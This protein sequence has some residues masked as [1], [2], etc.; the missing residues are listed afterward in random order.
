MIEIIYINS[1]KWNESQKLYYW[2]FQ[3]MAFGNKNRGDKSS[4]WSLTEQFPHTRAKIALAL[5]FTRNVTEITLALWRLQ[6]FILTLLSVNGKNSWQERVN[7]QKPL[8][9]FKWEKYS[10]INVVF[11]TCFL[12]WP[13]LYSGSFTICFFV[14]FKLQSMAGL[15]NW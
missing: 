10:K 11:I 7:Q 12:L 1:K 6:R 13:L 9:L 8:S 3:I 2:S 5:F 4:P 14:F 15:C